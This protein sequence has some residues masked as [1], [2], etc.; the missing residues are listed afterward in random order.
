MLP[1]NEQKAIG[2]KYRDAEKLKAKIRKL[3]AEALGALSPLEL[4]GELARD[5]LERAK[6]PK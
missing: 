3:K 5:R 1:Y 6:P 4:E 2:D